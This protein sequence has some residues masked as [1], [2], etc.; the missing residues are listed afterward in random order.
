MGFRIQKRINLGG[1]LGLNVGKKGVSTSFR[2]NGGSFSSKGYSVK[3]GISGVS[4][5]GTFDKSKSGCLVLTVLGLS[6]SAL[7]FSFIL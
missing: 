6:I 4:Y 5:R 1:G 3:T 7:L 2:G